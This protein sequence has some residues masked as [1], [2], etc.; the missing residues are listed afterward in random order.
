MEE[1]KNIFLLIYGKKKLTSN[2]FILN[3]IDKE[4]FLKITLQCPRSE[5]FDLSKK[6]FQRHNIIQIFSILMSG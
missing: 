1:E 5:L 4:M 2:V 6:F 3:N